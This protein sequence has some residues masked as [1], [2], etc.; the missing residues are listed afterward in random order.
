MDLV[1][2]NDV[3]LPIPSSYYDDVEF[4]ENSTR[5]ANATLI[6]EI[7]AKKMTINLQW[8]Y[9]TKVQFKQLRDIR[10]LKS[11]SCKYWDHQSEG[12]KTIT[13]YAGKLSGI[14]IRAN[15]Q[16]GIKDWR[17]VSI[18]FIEY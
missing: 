13:C 14:P 6:R 15:D 2:V 16:G 12:Y 10:E 9:L 7:I 1:L 8:N 17:D 5:N 3:A 18:N 11:F 4:L